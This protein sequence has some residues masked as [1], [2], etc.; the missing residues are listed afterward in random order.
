MKILSVDFKYKNIK[1]NAQIFFMGQF[2]KFFS[3][4]KYRLEFLMC[5]WNYSSLRIQIKLCKWD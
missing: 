3:C 4:C 2:F 1:E 5:K